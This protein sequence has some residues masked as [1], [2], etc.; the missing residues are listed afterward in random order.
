M[1]A[2]AAGSVNASNVLRL[3]LPGDELIFPGV[4]K[5]KIQGWQADPTALLDARL[6][7]V[8][9]GVERTLA[10][11][12]TVCLKMLQTDHCLHHAL[13]GLFMFGVK[14]LDL[15]ERESYATELLTRWSNSQAVT[16]PVERLLARIAL[17][18]AI[19]SLIHR[20]TASRDSWWG[21]VQYLARATLD[22]AVEAARRAGHEVFTQALWGPYKSVRVSTER[23]IQ[24]DTGSVPPGEVLACLRVAATIDGRAYPGRVLYRSTGV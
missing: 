1:L 9:P 7:E 3:P 20:P 21:K 24:A 14:P 16:E 15:A 11:V 4:G 10:G 13:Y 8:R 2:K 18:E 17:D 22:E 12:L 6:G 19:H 5:G 23:D